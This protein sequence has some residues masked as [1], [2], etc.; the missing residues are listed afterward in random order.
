MQL[1]SFTP[2]MSITQLT[3]ESHLPESHL[4]LAC[5]FW[6]ITFFQKCS[7]HLY[8]PGLLAFF[9]SNSSSAYPMSSSRVSSFSMMSVMSVAT[10]CSVLFVD[11]GLRSMANTQPA[12][13][14]SPGG[15]SRQGRE[16]YGGT[17]CLV[18]PEQGRPSLPFKKLLKTQLFREHL[19]S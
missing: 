11:S 9:P 13:Q 7:S 3:H 10:R 14:G 2:P 19:P 6:T 5:H 12:G 17:N 15:A 18:L 8:P 4:P 1:E 16:C